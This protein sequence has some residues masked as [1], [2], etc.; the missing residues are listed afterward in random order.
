MAQ[1]M[2]DA[3]GVVLA[4]IESNQAAPAVADTSFWLTTI[5]PSLDASLGAIDALIASGR[6]AVIGNPELSRRLAG[7]RDRVEDAVEEQVQAW[8]VQVSIVL[9]HLAEHDW[10]A[11]RHVGDAFWAQDRVPGRG[12]EYRGSVTLP[13]GRSLVAGFSVLR[14]LHYV[15]IGEFSALLEEFDVI[16]RL[17]E[18]E[19]GGVEVAGPLSNKELLLS[20]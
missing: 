5:T 2:V 10:N 4:A 19:V 11:T 14:T 20:A 16:E 12:L 15:T 8:E 13:S 3:F 1:R 9:P 18:L 17:I 6:M 7:L